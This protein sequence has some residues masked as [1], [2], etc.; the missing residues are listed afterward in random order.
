M[1]PYE[2]VL[3]A[4][5]AA[6]PIGEGW[7]DR[8]FDMTVRIAAMTGEHSPYTQAAR[9]VMDSAMFVAEYRG[10]EIEK[11]STRAKVTLYSP[12]GQKDD[13]LEQ[14][15]TDRTDSPQGARM[16][17][18]LAD[19][20]PGTRLAVWKFNEPIA[21]SKMGETV[22]I[23]THFEVL[24]GA[25]GVAPPPPSRGA[26]PPATADDGVELT[27]SEAI[28]E[29]LKK[30]PAAVVARIARAMREAGVAFPSPAE[31][32]LDRALAI[33]REIVEKE[34]KR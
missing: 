18:A 30:W 6:G 11:S 5:G 17:A 2:I 25:G 24:G 4:V 16:V 27:P 1:T 22:R 20:E 33:I 34:Q 14:I 12:R 19:I 21:G 15:R 31:E 7:S 10:F 9:R 26:P 3:A 32:D 28:Q 23:L 8:V 13:G 29:G